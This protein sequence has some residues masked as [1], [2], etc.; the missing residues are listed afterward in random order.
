VD[1]AAQLPGKLWIGEPD[2]VRP[3]HDRQAKVSVFPTEGA[4]PLLVTGE[5]IGFLKVPKVFEAMNQEIFE[6]WEASAY[7][8][9]EMWVDLSKVAAYEI[10]GVEVM[11][12][13]L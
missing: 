11:A 8:D 9:F 5:N 1:E 7:L 2:L 12:Q 10:S 13:V 3:F 6:R 4:L